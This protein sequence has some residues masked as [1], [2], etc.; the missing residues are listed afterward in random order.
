MSAVTVRMSPDGRPVLAGRSW[1]GFVSRLAPLPLTCRERF[2]AQLATVV[3][4]A[5]PPSAV[6]VVRLPLLT[7][8]WLPLPASCGLLC[9]PVCV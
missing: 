1:P 8:G 9:L 6:A 3:P 5:L 2:L 4:L 7:A